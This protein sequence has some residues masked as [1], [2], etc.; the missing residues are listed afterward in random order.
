MGPRLSRVAARIATM[1]TKEGEFAVPDG[2]IIAHLQKFL[3][4]KYAIDMAY[5]NFSD[6]IR[7]PF[8]DALAEHWYEH[9][10]D[11]RK[12]IYALNMKVIGM[13]ADPIQSYV[14]IPVC[15]PNV[16]AFVQVLMQM[17]LDAI[18]M[19]R[20]LAEIAGAN[21]GLRVFAEDTVVLDTHHLDDLRRWADKTKT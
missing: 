8:R 5:R 16:G 12:N 10:D 11:E 1:P 9:A 15:T 4:A 20:Q 21:I 7:G 3:S 13:G 17:E 18:E 14:Q 6:R 2:Q 19:G